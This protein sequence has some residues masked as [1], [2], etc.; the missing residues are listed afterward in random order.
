MS[1]KE[2]KTVITLVNDIVDLCMSEAGHQFTAKA[3]LNEVLDVP[4]TK[5]C[6]K[7]ILNLVLSQ[8]AR[9][10]DGVWHYLAA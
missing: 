6:E 5:S 10:P 7:K 9:S 4:I 1:K 2:K 3:A 8:I